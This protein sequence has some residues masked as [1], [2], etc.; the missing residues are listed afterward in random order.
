MDT[1]IRNVDVTTV[2]SPEAARAA[3]A[4][5]AIQSYVLHL[6]SLGFTRYKVDEIRHPETLV[7]VRYGYAGG[8][9]RIQTIDPRGCTKPDDIDRW[10]VKYDHRHFPLPSLEQLIDNTL[11]GPSGDWVR[12]HD[13]SGEL[14]IRHPDA[15]RVCDCPAQGVLDNG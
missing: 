13:A 1:A 4:V 9:W 8:E 10:T 3:L 7:R 15:A 6:Y 14:V 12:H 2:T 5:D 11:G